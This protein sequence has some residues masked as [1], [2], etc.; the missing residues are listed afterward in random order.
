[1]TCQYFTLNRK[2]NVLHHRRQIECIQLC[3]VL[4]SDGIF[5]LTHDV[6]LHSGQLSERIRLH[7]LIDVVLDEGVRR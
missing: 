2:I 6:E 4:R 1:M 5:Q 3:G 7:Q